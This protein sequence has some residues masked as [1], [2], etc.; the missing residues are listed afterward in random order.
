MFAIAFVGRASFVA[1]SS[2]MPAQ[3]VA[4]GL[5]AGISV[6]FLA[7]EPRRTARL[8]GK[9]SDLEIK[10]PDAGTTLTIDNFIQ[11]IALGNTGRQVFC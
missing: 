3:G 11:A 4:E 10:L 5:A 6:S 8:P 2:A 1:P 9:R 7:I